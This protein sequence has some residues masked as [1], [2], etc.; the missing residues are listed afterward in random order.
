[1]GALSRVAI[2]PTPLD[3]ERMHAVCRR[4]PPFPPLAA[5]LMKLF[6]RADASLQDAAVLIRS[7]AVFSGELLRLANSAEFGGYEPFE[8]VS[9]A[10]LYLGFDRVQGAIRRITY[11]RLMNDA[12]SHAFAAEIHRNNIAT[13]C[14]CEYLAKNFVADETEEQFCPYTMGLYLKIGALVLLRGFPRDYPR[15]LHSTVC[16]EAE[17]LE[18]ERTL[19][20]FSHIEISR[21]LAGYWGFPEELQ[22][23]IAQQ[24]QP[25]PAGAPATLG[26]TARLAS[27]MAGALGFSFLKSLSYEPFEAL[28]APWINHQPEGFPR[29]AAEWRERI[30]ARLEELSL[31]A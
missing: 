5:Q 3:L 27:R 14:L 17:L 31:A 9:R 26:E 28:V 2:A 7:D 1:M 21:H 22:A 29:R 23:L 25:I 4:L 12:F 8:D 20:G 19:F 13:A 10:V 24:E 30:G 15:F 18:A 6:S 11:G 16:G